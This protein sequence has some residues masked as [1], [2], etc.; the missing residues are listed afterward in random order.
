V[1]HINKSNSR[2]LFPD[3]ALVWGFNSP[4][5]WRITQEDV[6]SLYR[7]NVSRNHCEIAVGTGLHLSKVIPLIREITLI[8]LNENCLRVCEERIMNDHHDE[9]GNVARPVISKLVVDIAEQPPSPGEDAGYTSQLTPLQGKFQS[10]GVNFLFHCLHGS[11]LYDKVDAFRNCA[12]LLDPED[13]VFFG[14][15]ILGKE[16]L[17]DEDSAGETSIRAL[18][19]LNSMGVFGN[20]GDSLIDLDRILRD[21]FN[22]VN[23]RRIGYCGVWEAAHPKVEMATRYQAREDPMTNGCTIMNLPNL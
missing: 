23:V 12:S 16:I 1:Q 9:D 19:A 22:Y 11:N 10:V 5:L 21:I 18:G 20:L 4:F 13:G 3:D 17:N 14:S 7:A 8:D 15:T 2:P 6:S